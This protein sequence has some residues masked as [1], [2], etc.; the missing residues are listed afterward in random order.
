MKKA[1]NSAFIRK[2]SRLKKMRFLKVTAVLL[3]LGFIFQYF[4]IP[5]AVKAAPV[6]QSVTYAPTDPTALTDV[7]TADDTAD[8]YSQLQSDPDSVSDIG[9]PD[10]TSGAPSTDDNLAAPDLQMSPM[11]S[12]VTNGNTTSLGKVHFI[13]GTWYVRSGPSTS[14]GAITSITGPSWNDYYQTSSGWARIGSGWVG[15]AAIDSYDNNPPTDTSTSIANVTI[16]GYDVYVYGVSDVGSGVNYVLCPTW[17][18]TNGQD[19]I[20]WGSATNQGGG[21]W[22]YHVNRSDHKN[23]YIGYDTN[24]YLYD[25]AGNI[26]WGGAPVMGLSLDSTPPTAPTA[27]NLRKH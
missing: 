18:D 21:T 12:I 6:S 1:T 17:T 2:I 10:N 20:I 9:G 11:T 23:E 14:Y 27:I 22:K 25:N 5:P 19:D 15:P 26:A 24:V 8:S 16:N 3:V 7:G 4:V 13:S